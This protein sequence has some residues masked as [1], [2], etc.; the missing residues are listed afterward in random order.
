[1]LKIE[2]GKRNASFN[3]KLISRLLEIYAYVIMEMPGHYTTNK[4]FVAGCALFN[5]LGHRHPLIG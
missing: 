4:P 5:T 1:M 2:F 3:R